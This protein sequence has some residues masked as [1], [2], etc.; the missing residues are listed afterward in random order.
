MTMALDSTRNTRRL[1]T[2]LLVSTVGTAATFLTGC[3]G[4]GNVAE[5]TVV[6]SRHRR[7]SMTGSGMKPR[8][9]LAIAIIRQHGPQVN[10]Q[11]CW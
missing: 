5:K 11:V 8:S 6:A 9:K 3:G 1:C 2:G 7:I 4:G 10:S